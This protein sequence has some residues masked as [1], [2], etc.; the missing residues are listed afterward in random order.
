VLSKEKITK[1]NICEEKKEAILENKKKATKNKMENLSLIVP[2]IFITKQV[3][4]VG[5]AE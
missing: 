1:K 4:W 5:W 3:V 2:P